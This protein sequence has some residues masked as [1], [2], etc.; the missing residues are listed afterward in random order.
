MSD[1]IQPALRDLLTI[2]VAKGSRDNR[3]IHFQ[4]H[5]GTVG[6]PREDGHIPSHVYSERNRLMLSLKNPCLRQVATH[7]ESRQE[8]SQCRF[9]LSFDFWGEILKQRSDAGHGLIMEHSV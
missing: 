2:S 5:I 6:G 8:T 3:M 1:D 7:H 4:A 9:D